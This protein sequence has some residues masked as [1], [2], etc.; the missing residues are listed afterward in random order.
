VSETIKEAPGQVVKTSVAVL[1]NADAKPKVSVKKVQSLVAAAAGLS[2]AN[3]DQLVVTAMPFAK[4]VTSQA[5][6]LAAL[7]STNRLHLIEHAGEVAALVALI[8]AMLVL[9]LRASRRPVYDEV[10]VSELSSLGSRSFSHHDEPIPL[11]EHSS[12]PSPRTDALP[13]AAVLSQVNEFIEQ[14][15]AE[16]ARLLRA[17][18]E[19]GKE[20]T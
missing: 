5:G 7:E 2:V 4:T 13:P 15:P 11:R 14:R 20:A 1:L 9:A 8:I 16:V 12:S 10:H 17:W 6:A 3:G 19:E 18:V